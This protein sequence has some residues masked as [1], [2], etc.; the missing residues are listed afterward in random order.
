MP[1]TKDEV[2]EEKQEFWHILET[3]EWHTLSTAILLLLVANFATCLFH[4]RKWRQVQ[5]WAQREKGHTNSVASS[6]GGQRERQEQ[7]EGQRLDLFLASQSSTT[8]RS[9]A[10]TPLLLSFTL[11]ATVSS[12]RTEGALKGSWHEQDGRQ[13]KA[14]RSRL[15][16]SRL[17]QRAN[18]FHAVRRDCWSQ[19]ILFGS[20]TNRL[21][22]EF[23]G[24][25]RSRSTRPRFIR[26]V[27]MQGVC[28]NNWCGWV[29]VWKVRTSCFR[30]PWCFLAAGDAKLVS[31]LPKRP[32]APQ[33]FTWPT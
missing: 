32:F 9:R 21:W 14:A 22:N 7:E 15:R 19:V 26:W 4:S 1:P 28:D 24:Y 11:E 20:L 5:C 3:E 23:C 2:V 13:S 10:Q 31:R 17:R 30:C 12:S 18:T 29:C 6:F 27:S 16:P 25:R 33:L 8:S